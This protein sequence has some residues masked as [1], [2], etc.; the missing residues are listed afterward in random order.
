MP[1]PAIAS[2]RT[3]R[4]PQDEGQRALERVS[5]LTVENA[6]Y[7]LRFHPADKCEPVERVIAAGLADMQLADPGLTAD[8]V[9]VRGGRVGDGDTITR[10]RRHAHGDTY[11]LVTHTTSIEAELGLADVPAVLAPA[12]RAF[13]PEDPNA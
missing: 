6:L 13:D 9:I 3:A 11:W 2:T 1:E 7:I 12:P 4:I 10:L 8:A 5:G